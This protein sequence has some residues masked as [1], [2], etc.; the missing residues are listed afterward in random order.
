MNNKFI[1]ILTCIMMLVLLVTTSVIPVM[2]A[3]NTT[4]VNVHYV[5]ADTSLKDFYTSQEYYY[6][7]VG[8]DTAEEAVKLENKWESNYLY[9]N[10]KNG[11]IAIYE[12]EDYIKK[13]AEE[14]QFDIP[15]NAV[16]DLINKAK[17]YDYSFTTACGKNFVFNEKTYNPISLYGQDGEL[18]KGKDY[19]EIIGCLVDDYTDYNNNDYIKGKSQY[20]TNGYILNANKSEMTI[21]VLMTP[22]TYVDY[23]FIDNTV[24][25]DYKI[26]DRLETDANTTK[27]DIEKYITKQSK[28]TD[29]YQY[30]KYVYDNVWEYKSSKYGSP[31]TIIDTRNYIDVFDDV[32]YPMSNYVGYSFDNIEVSSQYKV[33]NN[34]ITIMPFAFS[35]QEPLGHI[36]LN[37]KNTSS[38]SIRFE[39]TDGNAVP[40]NLKGLVYDN[41]MASYYP[42]SFDHT[43]YISLETDANPYSTKFDDDFFVTE[44]KWNNELSLI[45]Y[46]N[47]EDILKTEEVKNDTNFSTVNNNSYDV[48]LEKSILNNV[49]GYRLKYINQNDAD[50]EYT[51][52][53]KNDNEYYY[54]GNTPYSLTDTTTNV[55]Y[56]KS[57]NLTVNYIDEEGKELAPSTIE[58]GWSSEEYTTVPIDIEG[59]ELMAVPDNAVGVFTTQN[60]TVNYVYKKVPTVINTEP[61]EPTLDIVKEETT[62]QEPQKFIV[63]DTGDNN[64]VK[65][66]FAF[67]AILIGVITLLLVATRKNYNKSS[68]NKK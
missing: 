32:K 46:I 58:Q 3:T 37:Y 51:I 47:D 56:E 54:N 30:Y 60:V 49:D 34:I 18:W 7:C 12:P 9:P 53:N 62:I 16:N 40:F 45:E 29:K 2:A 59:Y 24:Y 57:V 13:K 67:V 42:N 10:I 33:E 1:K 50:T 55:I 5:V 11:S 41:Y 4:T 38:H 61:Q 44:I 14:S 36:N 8:F 35:S 66:I 6:F 19:F 25:S 26:N 15:Q 43:K 22:T 28:F 48:L 23:N 65:Y 39:D 52:I 64:N 21:Y 68:N 20:G 31:H 63:I 17:E 27:E